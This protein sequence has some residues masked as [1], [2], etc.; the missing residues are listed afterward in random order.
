MY[1]KSIAKNYGDFTKVVVYN[2]GV[3]LDPPVCKLHLLP[4]CQ[5]CWTRK[6]NVIPKPSSLMR[7]KTRITDY[8]LANNFDLFTTFTFDPQKVDSL[9]FQY[10]KSKMS[11][12]L[13]IQK[14]SSPDLKYLIVAELHKESGRIH[15]HA[16]LKNFTGELKLA[17]NKNNTVKIKNGRK[18]YNIGNYKWGWSTAVKIDNIEKVSSYIQKYITKDMLKITNKK[19]YWTSRNLVKPQ[20]TYNVPLKE[21]VYSRPLF[22]QGVYKEEYYKIYT[23]LN[24]HSPL[25]GVAVEAESGKQPTE[26]ENVGWLAH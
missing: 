25:S 23:I 11:N 9:D 4:V 5:I 18:I 22:I 26:R 3:N 8:T 2:K 16:L 20:K 10:A 21:E 13:K 1:I 24:I 6:V 15:F 7:S 17:Y 19:R 14:R 12:W